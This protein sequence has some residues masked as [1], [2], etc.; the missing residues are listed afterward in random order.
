MAKKDEA[1]LRKAVE[2]AQS[3][4]DDLREKYAKKPDERTGRALL[5][6]R[7]KASEALRALWDALPEEKPPSQRLG[8]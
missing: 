3:K 5:T 1:A 6:A 7:E 8:M 4:V 2:Q